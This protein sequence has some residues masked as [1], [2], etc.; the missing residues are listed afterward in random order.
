MVS[1]VKIEQSVAIRR[2][3]GVSH[4]ASQWKRED[5]MTRAYMQEQM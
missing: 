5:H 2:A 4:R 3:S 1:L